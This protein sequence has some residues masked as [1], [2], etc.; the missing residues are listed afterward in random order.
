MVSGEIP[1]HGPN[2]EVSRNSQPRPNNAAVY[3]PGMRYSTTRR[4]G[5]PI[6]LPATF[7]PASIALLRVRRVYSALIFAAF[8]VGHH[9]SI[10]V[11]WNA[12]S[13]SGVCCS[14]GG[15]TED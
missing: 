10:S 6:P 14:R 7:F 12:P 13:D 11:R 4:I 5:A 9:L 15:M 2:R 8:M 1:E 3:N